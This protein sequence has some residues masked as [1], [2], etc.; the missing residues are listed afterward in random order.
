MGPARR[1]VSCKTSGGSYRIESGRDRQFEVETPYLIAGVKGTVFSV[2]V[3]TAGTTVSVSEGVVSV[4]R[5]GSFVRPVDL[6]AGQS[7]SATS[8]PGATVTVTETDQPG[9]G[10]DSQGAVGQGE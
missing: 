3:T 10:A 9:E 5:P 2:A 6:R 8:S 1:P 7:G 4:F